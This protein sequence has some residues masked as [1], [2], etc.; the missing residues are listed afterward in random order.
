[1]RQFLK[2]GW[3][4]LKGLRSYGG[5]KLRVS[6]IPIGASFIHILVTFLR[7]ETFFDV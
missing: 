6:G 1:M 2:L 5:F 4:S 3:E 7:F